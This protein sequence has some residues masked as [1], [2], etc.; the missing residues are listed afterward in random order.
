MSLSELQDS[1]RVLGV[2]IT[3]TDADI[4]KAYR[5]LSLR[6]HPDK[7]GKDVDPVLAAE[8]FHKIS[9]AYETLKD[10]AARA[11]AQQEA[12]EDASKRE[13]QSKYEGKRRQMADELDKDEHE[14]V[15]RKSDLLRRT[16][17]RQ[18]LIVKL[19][20]EARRAVLQKQ[21]EEHASSSVAQ[22][23]DQ[24]PAL[25]PLDKTVRIRFPSS[26]FS[27]LA[28]IPTLAHP[29]APLA[30]PLAIALALQFGSLD[31]LQFQLPSAS[32]KAKREMTALASFRQF[33]DAWQAVCTGSELRGTG[34]LQD[35]YIGWVEQE[36][37]GSKYEPQRV[38]WYANQ[39]IHEPRRRQATTQLTPDY[40]QATLQRLVDAEQ[41][42]TQPVI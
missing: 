39:G 30:T 17:K 29:T 15:S 25:Q 19:K 34:V 9:L 1:F 10:P 33:D 21:A 20:E 3:S 4:R 42:R 13:R 38:Q 18:E 23:A 12:A 22:P 37:H 40:E 2:S 6:Y 31:H 7:A 36:A 5:K 28:G 16:T 41:H 32:R 11:R 24:E 26:Q 35:A 27:Q 8:R 14:A